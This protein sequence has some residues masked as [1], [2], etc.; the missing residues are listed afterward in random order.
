MMGRRPQKA[1]YTYG[2][3]ASGVA[4]VVAIFFDD[5]DREERVMDNNLCGPIR[6]DSKCRVL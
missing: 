2:S 6:S 1:D 5:V 3:P 4:V